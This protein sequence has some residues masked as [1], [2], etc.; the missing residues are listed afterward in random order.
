MSYASNTYDH[1]SFLVRF[2]HRRRLALLARIIGARPVDRWLDY[3]AGDG[4]VFR[5]VASCA[6]VR[7]AV[8]YEPIEESFVQ[9]EERLCDGPYRLAS[10][11]AEV[12]GQFDLVTAFEVLE[13]LPLPERIRF[14][15]FAAEHLAPHGRMVIEV[16][17]EVGPVLLL[18][19]WGRR[20]F[21]KRPSAYSP[22]ELFAAGMLGRV[23]DTQERYDAGDRRTSIIDHH[24]FDIKRFAREI[25]R[26]GTI[27]A[28]HNSPIAALPFWLNQCRVFEFRL[29]CRDPA[30]IG[31]AL[32]EAG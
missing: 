27:V 9:A 15:Q 2:P 21:K 5:R 23:S 25:G 12:E 30:A 28:S 10:N 17:V 24:G 7:E 13:H 32:R 3:G 26:I 14:F 22:G 29:E 11:L 4:E 31:A 19:E 8:L 1:P 16:P 20:I 6:E 18:K